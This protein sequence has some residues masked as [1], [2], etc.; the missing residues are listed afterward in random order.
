MV[1]TTACPD[2]VRP[3]QSLATPMAFPDL[4]DRRGDDFLSIVDASDVGMK[5]VN[6]SFE[7]RCVWTGST[8]AK[9]CHSKAEEIHQFLAKNAVPTETLH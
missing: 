1:Y 6:R 2:L 8:C 9:D 3:E 7:D 4:D 5:S